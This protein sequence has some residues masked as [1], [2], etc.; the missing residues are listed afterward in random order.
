MFGKRKFNGL[1]S[2]FDSLFNEMN[3]M[4]YDSPLYIKGK[5]NVENGK[6]ENGM[7]TKESFISDDGT[8]MVT[9]IIR[10]NSKTNKPEKSNN[11]IETLKLELEKAVNDQEFEKAVKLRDKIKSL[12]ENKE[13]INELKAKL[14]E[15]IS[16]Q[17]FEKAIKL[18]D[19]IKELES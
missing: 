16:K 6:D 5:S 11:Q 3:S 7:W 17:D 4:F 14:E 19:Q 15:S 18:R 2:D 8:Y 10:T 13:K 12:E 9:T 1:F